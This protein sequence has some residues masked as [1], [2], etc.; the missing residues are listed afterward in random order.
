MLVQFD[1]AVG[2]AGYDFG[3]HFRNFLPFLS[4]ETVGHEPFP[5]EFLREL[6]LPLS[7]CE[8]FLITFCVEVS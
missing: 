8:S 2:D 7:L 5:Y 4:L 1:I 6:L 3:S